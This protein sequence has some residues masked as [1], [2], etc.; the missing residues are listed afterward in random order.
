MFK[1]QLSNS[2]SANSKQNESHLLMYPL[3]TQTPKLFSLNGVPFSQIKSSSNSSIESI[4]SDSSAS[5]IKLSCGDK[6]AIVIPNAPGRNDNELQEMIFSVIMKKYVG[7]KESSRRAQDREKLRDVYH[8]SLNQEL[9]VEHRETNGDDFHTKHREVD[10]REYG[11]LK[12]FTQ[13]NDESDSNRIQCLTRLKLNTTKGSTELKLN[14]NDG[15][16]KQDLMSV[17]NSES[18]ILSMEHFSENNLD[19]VSLDTSDAMQ[20]HKSLTSI[21]S[22]G[23]S[24]NDSLHNS[25]GIPKSENSYH[26]LNTKRSK[27]SISKDDLQLSSLSVAQLKR[28]KGDNEKALGAKAKFRNTLLDLILYWKSVKSPDDSIRHFP[29]LLQKTR[30]S[31]L[32]ENRA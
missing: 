16:K 11:L 32:N 3:G 14:E 1:L 22:D 29:V 28:I 17:G 5:S 21:L 2:D 6:I 25:E 13:E 23:C 10:G 15:M 27:T 31:C 26:T 30:T 7:G 4:S 18:P 12:Q 20:R 9:A 24:I 19:S 8:P